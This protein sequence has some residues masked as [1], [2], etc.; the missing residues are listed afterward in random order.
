MFLKLWWLR[1]DG[2]MAAAEG[3]LF[4]EFKL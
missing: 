3:Q 1:V 4:C 2:G